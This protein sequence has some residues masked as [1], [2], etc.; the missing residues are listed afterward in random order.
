[1][2]DKKQAPSARSS[3]KLPAQAALPVAPRKQAP[4]RAR[5][6]E[7]HE[8]DPFEDDEWL[9]KVRSEQE[10]ISRR[11]AETLFSDLAP[12]VPGELR[13]LQGFVGWENLR[14]PPALEPETLRVALRVELERDCFAATIALTEW[15]AVRIVLKAVERLRRPNLTRKEIAEV[16][17]RIAELPRARKEDLERL[18]RPTE[19]DELPVAV[20]ERVQD[21]L[22]RGKRIPLLGEVRDGKFF[23]DVETLAHWAEGYDWTK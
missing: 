21:F 18:S 22:A 10:D 16:L 13:A 12:K 3:G 4:E 2:M 17:P 19:Y 1:M 5:D 8:L 15:M 11:F 23:V 9:R 7:L 14:D 20:L 6:A